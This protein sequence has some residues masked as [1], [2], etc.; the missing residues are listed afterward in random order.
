MTW[1]RSKSSKAAGFV[2]QPLDTT[3]KSIRVLKIRPDMKNSPIECN[4][5]HQVLKEDGHVCLSYMWGPETPLK[6]IIINGCPFPVRQ[7][8]WR[9][10]HTARRLWP[11]L[12][13]WLWIDAICIDQQ[14][15]AERNHQVQQMADIY[16]LARKVVVWPEPMQ[17]IPGISMPLSAIGK[18]LYKSLAALSE[19]STTC[20]VALLKPPLYSPYW[21][22]LWILQELFVAKS[23]VVIIGQT[24]L[25]WTDFLH[26]YHVQ[27]PHLRNWDPHNSL[28]YPNPLQAIA[29]EFGSER[30][31]WKSTGGLPLLSMALE[32]GKGRKCSDTRDQFYGLL[33]LMSKEF[34][35]DYGT[36]LP[37]L[38]A[39]IAVQFYP[40]SR[41]K[42]LMSINTLLK[43]LQVSCEGICDCCKG[44]LAQGQRVRREHETRPSALHL[45]FYKGNGQLSRM[46]FVSNILCC[47]ECGWFLYQHVLEV[48]PLSVKRAG[49]TSLT[50]NLDGWIETGIGLAEQKRAFDMHEAG[51]LT[52][53][54]YYT[55]G[56]DDYLREYHGKFTTSMPLA[57]SH[58]P[59]IQTQGPSLS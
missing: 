33:G 7:N 36:E 8:L 17:S 15:I 43:S 45:D 37:E 12:N 23:L 27:F 38:A 31:F 44:S 11:Q 56:W 51:K 4:L 14:N 58:T 42:E 35:V 30:I 39:N 10:M 54:V 29:H 57:S 40:F 49:P 34:H 13:V 5:R 47:L 25:S 48:Q 2:H 21:N 22:R 41:I 59:Q 3:V 20:G 26:L 50:V 32:L 16:K 52:K 46:A 55:F 1:A 6:T 53:S 28:T 9:F 24:I 19:I 18:I